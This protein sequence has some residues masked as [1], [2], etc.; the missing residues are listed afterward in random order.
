VRWIHEDRR[1]RASCHRRP[2]CSAAERRLLLILS[3]G[4][5]NDVDA[6]EGP[7]GVED[8]RQAIAEAR[9]Q[10]VHVLCLTVDRDA[11][12]YA[13][14]IFGKA[15]FTVVHRADQLP[16]VLIELLRRLIHR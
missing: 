1:R 11:P 16:E 15:G 3:D 9:A 6:Y 2:E 14:R 12:R 7:Y 13:T 8:A 4:K 5:P 10:N